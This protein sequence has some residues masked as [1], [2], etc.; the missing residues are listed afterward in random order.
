M[1]NQ[2]VR[3]VMESR[4]LLKAPPQ[5]SVFDAA[6]MMA[7]K[8]LG[9]VMIIE[10]EHLVGIFT[11]RDVV[12]RV[13][14]RGLDP[15]ATPVSSVMTPAPKT[16]DPEKPFGYALLMMHKSGFRHVPVV[17]NGKPIGMVSARNALDPDM[18]EFVAEAQR[19]RHIQEMT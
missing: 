19:R 13:V 10:D 8:N 14:A 15:K 18:E 5:M 1:Y 16:V 2:P 4:K 17:E 9:A 3:S 6:H 12:F 7:K 11:E